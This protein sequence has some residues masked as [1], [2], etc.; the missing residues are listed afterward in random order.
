MLHGSTSRFTTSELRQ[1][2]RYLEGVIV[3][4]GRAA[5]GGRAEVFAPNSVEWLADGIDIL[6]RH[7]GDSE[8]KA[9][10]VRDAEGRIRIRA[11]AT[12]ALR[13][14]FAAGR[15]FLSVEFVA[16]KEIRT[17]GGVREIQSALVLAAALVRNPEYGMA[18]AEL[19][20]GGFR[21]RSTIP[22]D[23]DLDCDCVGVGC[24]FAR[25]T[26]QA[27]DEMWQRVTEA[28][29]RRPVIAAYDHF[30]AVLGSAARGSVR[31][32]RVD[33]GL[34]VEIDLRES[35]AAR[36]LLAADEAAGVIVRPYIDADS[37]GIQEGETV[38]YDN[39]ILRAFIVSP[40]DRRGGWNDA[41]I[42]RGEQRTARRKRRLWL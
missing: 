18:V 23:T 13:R 29:A 20:Q 15:R 19:R 1:S 25:F 7:L 28:H 6:A 11:L 39:P 36:Q 10:P 31:A 3:Q 42:E 30:S 4:E 2:G 14:A 21:L 9:I 32:K 26:A 41:V 8:V 16:K 38:I 5:T 37:E 17:L 35:E 33:D 27:M 12:D 24:K 22:Q 34:D 40:T